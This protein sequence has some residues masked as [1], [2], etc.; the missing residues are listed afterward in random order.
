M[1]LNLTFLSVILVYSSFGFPSFLQ[2]F[3]AAIKPLWL[4]AS[5]YAPSAKLLDSFLPSPFSS[6]PN[7]TYFLL[8]TGIRPG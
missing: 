7:L 2:A 8:R 4:S 5:S 3:N 1:S 6:S